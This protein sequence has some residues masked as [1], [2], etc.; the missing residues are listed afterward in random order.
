MNRRH[1]D[2]TSTMSQYQW[3]FVVV[4]LKN[5]S[6]VPAASCCFCLRLEAVTWLQLNRSLMKISQPINPISYI[7]CVLGFF[8]LLPSRKLC[9][10]W[11]LFVCTV[12]NITQKAVGGLSLNFQELSARDHEQVF[13]LWGWLEIHYGQKNLVFMYKYWANKKSTWKSQS[14]TKDAPSFPDGERHPPKI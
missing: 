10:H 13:R 6:N 11:G 5:N 3:M 2:R 8:F 9:F 7:T 4:L 1:D 14:S 12:S